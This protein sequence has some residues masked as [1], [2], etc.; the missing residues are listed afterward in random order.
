MAYTAI[1]Y[2]H[3]PAKN[4]VFVGFLLVMERFYIAVSRL[5]LKRV[6]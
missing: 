1:C 4:L 5:L 2:L 3:F 6:F